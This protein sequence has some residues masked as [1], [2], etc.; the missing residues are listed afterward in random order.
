M[1]EETREGKQRGSGRGVK[2]EVRELG[3]RL[4]EFVER[5]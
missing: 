1:R 2:G 4:E 3:G 5:E